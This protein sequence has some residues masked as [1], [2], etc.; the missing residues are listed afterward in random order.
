MTGQVNSVNTEWQTAQMASRAT[1]H[2]GDLK[3]ALVEA[4][5]DAARKGGEAAIGLN[6]LAAGVGVSASAAYR[7]FPH[8]LEDL[9]VAVGDVARRELADRITA[10]MAQTK[11]SRDAGTVARRRFRASGEAYVEYVLEQPGLFQVACRHDRGRTAEA[12][13]FGLLESCIDDLVRAGVLAARRR[14]Q[15]AMA[16]WAAVHG[17]ALLLTEGPLRRLPADRRRRVIDR[18]LD[19]VEAGL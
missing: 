11:A 7:H 5:V 14:D 12:D 6:R 8:G 10:R 19:M 15:A 16:A 2:H 4:G 13:P 3:A 17:L 9:L 1:Y 18:T